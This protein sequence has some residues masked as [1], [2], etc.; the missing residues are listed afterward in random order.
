MTGILP[1]VTATAVGLFAMQPRTVWRQGGMPAGGAKSSRAAER[2]APRAKQPLGGVIDD[3]LPRDFERSGRTLPGP[4]SRPASPIDGG[5]AK[6]REA[7]TAGLRDVIPSVKRAAA[8][9]PVDSAKPRRLVPPRYE[10]EEPAE[11]AGA[12]EPDGFNGPE[13]P[14][15]PSLGSANLDTFPKEPEDQEQPQ[16]KTKFTARPSDRKRSASLAKNE[17]SEKSKDVKANKKAPARREPP[18]PSDRPQASGKASGV[19][20]GALLGLFASL[21]TN[22]FLLWVAASQRH[23]Y[24]ALVRDMFENDASAYHAN[25]ADGRDDLPH[26]EEMDEEPNAAQAAHADERM[27]NHK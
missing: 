6:R 3:P 26:W 9:K 4:V 25:D 16:A 2:A 14:K 21:G 19:P 17:T 22:V 11:E 18:S 15:G 8:S 12:E 10:A 23:R 24:R 5:A 1:L 20:N 27:T 13:G 7:A